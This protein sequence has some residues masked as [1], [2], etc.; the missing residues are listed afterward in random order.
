MH[1]YV[2]QYVSIF[3]T[4]E[5]LFIDR[6]YCP[7]TSKTISSQITLDYAKITITKTCM[8]QKEEK[9]KVNKSEVR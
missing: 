3:S 1:F 7:V 4:K 6:A 8:L 9:M 2:I 5:E